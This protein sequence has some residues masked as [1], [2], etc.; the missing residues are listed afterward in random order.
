MILVLG[1]ARSCR[2]PNLGW[3]GAGSPQWF[4]VSQK[5][6]AWD[7]M[8]NQVCCHDEVANHQ[9]P[10]AAA[11]WIIL[12]VSAEKC[13]NWTHRCSTS[14]VILKTTATC[15]LNSIYHPHWLVQWSRHCSFMCIPVHSPWLPGYIDVMQT[16][17]I[18]L[19]MAGHFLDRPHISLGED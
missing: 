7:I 9:L 18:I 2:M 17:F 14:S 10:V 11:F 16:I 8:H 6:P 1:K 5:N 15:S 3:R 19:T 4:D 13:S 12:I